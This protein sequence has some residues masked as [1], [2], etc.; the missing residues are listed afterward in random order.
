MVVMAAMMATALHGG[1]DLT[2]AAAVS[3]MVFSI[4]LSSKGMGAFTF[5]PGFD[6]PNPMPGGTAGR[7][8]HWSLSFPR[9]DSRSCFL[10]DVSSL[11]SSL[12]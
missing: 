7:S 11:I 1:G 6:E 3:F 5:Y 2:M 4:V 9:L 12:K 10:G 8:Y